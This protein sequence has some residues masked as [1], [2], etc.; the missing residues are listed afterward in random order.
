MKMKFTSTKYKR[1]LM[2]SMHSLFFVN[3]PVKGFLSTVWGVLVYYTGNEP[4]ILEFICILL[5]CDLFMGILAAIKHRTLSSDFL[6]QILYK[7]AMYLVLLVTSA[8][9][10]GMCPYGWI[11]RD[12]FRL[13]I[14][15]AE[16]ISILENADLLGFKYAKRV[17]EVVNKEVE[18]KLNKY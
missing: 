2:D 15:S 5:V 18:K 10:V 17:I 16:V 6:V 12:V 9:F 11:L 4:K 13:L 7:A 8:A 1:Y 3:I 14:G